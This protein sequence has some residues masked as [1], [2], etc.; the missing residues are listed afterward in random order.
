MNNDNITITVS[1]EV[2]NNE[3]ELRQVIDF[4]DTRFF[5]HASNINCY[6]KDF[7]RQTWNRINWIEIFR[8]WYQRYE[9][10][11]IGQGITYTFN[12]FMKQIDPEGEF[13][14]ND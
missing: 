6:S 3:S 1:C 11:S 2:F 14:K 12:R 9:T 7:I 10:Q 8:W 4:F 5:G 13:Y